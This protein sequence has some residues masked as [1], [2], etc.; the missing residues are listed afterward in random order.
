MS[1]KRACIAHRARSVRYALSLVLLSLAPLLWAQ[2]LSPRITQAINGS[3]RTTIAGSR[4]PMARTADDTGPVPPGIKLQ[5]MT[6]VF[7]RTDSQEAELQ[8]LLAAQQDTSS[9]QYHKWLT[10]AEFATRFGVSDGDIAKVEAWLEQQGFSIDGAAM[11]RNRISF[12]GTAGQAETAFGTELHYYTSDGKRDFAPSSDLSIPAALSSVVQSVENL[13]TFRPKAHVRFK[14]PVKSNFTSSQ[15]GSHFLTPKDVA[16]IYDINPAYNAGYTGAGQSIAVVGQSSIELSDIENFRSAAGLAAKDPIVVLVPGSGSSASSSGDEAESDLDLEYTGGIAREATIYFVYVGNNTNYSVWDSI[17]YAVDT[18]IAPIISVSYGTCETGVSSSDYA[19]L[20]GILAQAASQGQT[21]VAASGDS[22]STDCYPTTTLTSTQRMALT[23]DY[24]ASSQ[25]VTGMGGSEFSSSDVAS[26]NT[27]YW[28]AASASDVIGSALSYIPEQVWNDDSSSDGISSGGGGVSTLT[29]RPSW[30]SGVTGISSGSYRLVPDV[31]LAASASNPGY[32]YCSSDSSSTGV[33]GSCA[34]GFRDAN[35]TY[36]T[37]AGGTS[38]ASPIFA[39]MLAIINQKLNSTGQ[40]NVNATLYTLAATSST[41]A[42]AFHDITT[43]SNKCTAGS[44]YC[45]TAGASQYAAT[46]GY[47]QATG[48]GSVNFN[49]LLNAW[50]T[51]SASS[52]QASTT[53]LSAAT[54]SPS[55]SASDTVTLGVSSASTSTTAVPTG[56]ISIS[57]DGT[58]TASSLALSSGSTTYA[59]SSSTS[60]AHV[61]VATYSGDSIYAA[62]TGSLTVTV[63]AASTASGS[64]A[65]ALS[66]TNV[67]VTA[68]SS[69]TSTITVT[70]KNGYTGTVEWS[71]S[72]SASLSNAC[73]DLSNVTVSGTNAVTAT[74]TIYTSASDCSNASVSGSGGS[75]HTIASA[76]SSKVRSVSAIGRSGLNGAGIALAAMSFAW[77]LPV[78]SRKRPRSPWLVLLILV[79]Y[80]ASGCGSSSSS[81]SSTSNAAKGSYQLTVTGTDTSTSSITASTSMTLT[82]N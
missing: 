1:L 80:L 23:V 34:N 33:T 49:N 30:Q 64:K 41:Y 3:E 58:T 57:V 36:L 76:G 82:V 56:T 59:F 6:I 10:P 79:G 77:L 70:P 38:F 69:G 78:A 71:V 27:T 29:T 45:S 73:Y 13:S 46:T 26:S 81:S 68:G 65:F 63:G 15:S 31:S 20:N 39:G 53:T 61:I 4:H 21:V 74:M 12:S 5:G 32:L 11:S 17:E 60:G 8:S 19:T 44:S 43:G 35:S 75:R 18:K 54:S 67:S 50:P 52:L 62:S 40:G 48:L 24:P 72:S 55:A 42:S 2:N 7:S 66:A 47:D 14:S 37:V 22:G 25:Y 28:Q 9:P 16:T 51:T